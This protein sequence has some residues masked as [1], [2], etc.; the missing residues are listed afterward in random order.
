MAEEELLAPA[1]TRE[2]VRAAEQGHGDEARAL[3]R[4]ALLADR[5]YEPAWL[6]LAWLVT[7]DGH[8]KYCLERAVGVN[9]E[10]LA[11]ARP[12]RLRK[13]TSAPPP[14]VEDFADPAPPPEPDRERPAWRRRAV[15]AALALTAVAVVTALVVLTLRALEDEPAP[16][17]VAVVAGLHRNSGARHRRDSRR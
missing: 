5:A 15:P 9:P 1:H 11:H 12:H 13:A 8:R 10:S 6:W 16:V 2:A 7:D 3:L 14:E 4:K 17:H